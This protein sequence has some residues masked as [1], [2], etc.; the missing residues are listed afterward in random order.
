M[1]ILVGTDQ[2]ILS[3]HDRSLELEGHKITSLTYGDGDWW[4]ITDG[5]EVRRFD[6]SS[7]T[8]VA[9]TNEFPLRCLS[10]TSKGLLV[11]TSEAHL[12]HEGRGELRVVDSFEKAPGRDGWYTPWGGPPDTRSI[13]ESKNGSIFV[14][15]HVGGI[16]RSRDGGESWEQT[17]DIDTDI[18]QVHAHPAQPDAVVAAC[19]R[20]FVRSRDG[21]NDWEITADGLHAS[22]SRAVGITG[23]W[24]LVS[25]STGPRGGRAA[26]YR[27]LLDGDEPFERCAQGLPEWFPGNI[28]TA[29]LGSREDTVAFGTEDGAVFL[30]EDSGETWNEAAI[31]LPPVRCLAIGE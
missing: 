16:L 14:N 2:G 15:V 9:S 24:V 19:A 3:L 5:A 8:V 1:K 11:G 25:A 4:A 29:C 18:H 22:Y 26:L 21:G 13:S 28:D 10:I 12:L 17:I 20:G 30:S 27:R 23:E 7:W 6:G 31:D